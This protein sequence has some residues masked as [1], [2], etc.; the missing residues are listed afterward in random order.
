MRLWSINPKYLDNK[1]LVAVWREGLLAKKVL[2]GKTK[3]YKNHPQLTRFREYTNPL[4]AINSYLFFVFVE[5]KN[6][7]HNFDESKINVS[8]LKK[9]IPVT[10]SQMNFEFKH[11]L[12]KLKERDL[13]KFKELRGL[14]LDEIISN[15]IFKIINGDIESW[16]KIT[17]KK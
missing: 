5:S 4:E 9:M 6:R 14:N 8:K 13:K 16:E 7:G 1:G 10:S 3:G 12:K 11:L 17:I 2:Q 15:P